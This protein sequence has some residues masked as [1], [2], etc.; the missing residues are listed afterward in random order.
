MVIDTIGADL[1]VF[2]TPTFKVGFSF[3]TVVGLLSKD[4]KKDIFGS[5]EESS[6]KY[7]KVLNALEPSD[8]SYST[9]ALKLEYIFYNG[10]TLAWSTTT[11]FGT[12]VLGFKPEGDEELGDSIEHLY[13]SLGVALIVKIT[14][15]FKMS[16]GISQ[17]KDFD[18]NSANRPEG[19]ENFDAVSIYN[20]FYLASF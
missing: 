10:E 7:N 11:N 6:K 15:N 20:H 12:G 5:I 18:A 16:I 8:F 14:K 17:R 4:P 19:Y 3:A 13:G 9:A 2:A 1:G